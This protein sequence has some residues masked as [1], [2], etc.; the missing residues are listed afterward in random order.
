MLSSTRFLQ[1]FVSQRCSPQRLARR[2]EPTALIER[3][4]S[5]LQYDQA[6][7]TKLV[8]SYLAAC[9]VIERARAS[10]AQRSALD[11][12][13][14]PGHMTTCLA[15]YLGY[16]DV[17]G[18]DLS[19]PMVEVAQKSLPAPLRERVRF[20]VQDITKLDAM[21]AGG[22]D[23]VTFTNAAHHLDGLGEVQQVLQAMDRL[24]GKSGLVML[25]D[26]ARLR[27]EALTEQYLDAF[28]ADYVAQG[29]EALKEEFRHSLYAA[30]TPDELAHAIPWRSSKRRWVQIV[31]RGLPMVQFVLGLPVGQE[32]AF[33]RGARGMQ[34]EGVLLDAWRPRWAQALGQR[35]A[36][37][38]LREW[39]LA[40]AMLLMAQHRSV[41]WRRQTRAGK[42]ASVGLESNFL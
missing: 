11:L 16:E 35:W 29:L 38:T 25:M 9:H 10:R 32:R 31:T 8:L 17:L 19:S 34:A 30:Y 20:E 21:P 1:L 13:C 2:P 26:V 40:K 5:V 18:I 3:S 41:P 15:H 42:T 37:E 12:A 24:A 28:C 23:L 4:A 39:H 7:C 14:G 33:A 6:M 27:N 22:F 36:Q